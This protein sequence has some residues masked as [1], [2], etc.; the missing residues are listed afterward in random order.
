M[1]RVSACYFNRGGASSDGIDAW[2]ADCGSSRHATNN[3]RDFV[4]GSIKA[5]RIEVHVGDGITI[6]T[7]MGDI[8][9]QDTKTREFVRLRDVL[10]L[11]V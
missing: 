1:V 10:L 5:I 8:M 3:I 11:P 4:R 7:K 6:V 2:I 9:L